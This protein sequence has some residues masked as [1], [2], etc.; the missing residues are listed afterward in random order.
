MKK[1]PAI[2]LMGPTASGKTDLAIELLARLP[3]EI[4]SVDSAMVYKGMDIGTGKP[5]SEVLA[6]APHHLIDIRDPSEPYSAADFA[7]EARKLMSEITARGKIP[8]LVGGTLLYFRALEQGLSLLPPADNAIRAR[9]WAEGNEMGW[10]QLHNRLAAIDPASAQR[11]H[12]HDPQR[13]QRALEV[14]EITGKPMSYFFQNTNSL[15]EGGSR[16]A[17][18]EHELYRFALLPSDRAILYERIERRFDRMLDL[19]L[20]DEVELLFK[21]GDLTPDLPAIR[22]V[23]YRQVWKYLEG[24]YKYDEMVYKAKVATRQLAKR[25]LTWLRQLPKLIELKNT[26]L[27]SIETVI[28]CVFKGSSGN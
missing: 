19:G 20:I 4:I 10:L 18:E 17:T 28:H 3:L 7:I 24:G 8:L 12:P 16:N 13:I 5:T 15:K 27:A 22:S 21:R 2:F 26:L 9:L 11:I 14:F 6:Y 23:G 1:P 25:Q